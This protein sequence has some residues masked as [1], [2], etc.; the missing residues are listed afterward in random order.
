MSKKKKRDGPLVV[1]SIKDRAPVYICEDSHN[2]WGQ[3]RVICCPVVDI[4]GRL[5]GKATANE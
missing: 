5:F 1:Y 4:I 3:R 2:P